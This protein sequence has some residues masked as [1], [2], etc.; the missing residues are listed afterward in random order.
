MILLTHY[1][2]TENQWYRDITDI[3]TCDVITRG[4]YNPN[5][6]IWQKLKKYSKTGQ[7]FKNLI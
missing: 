5:Q 4:N 3:I 1:I 6:N 7:D 2:A